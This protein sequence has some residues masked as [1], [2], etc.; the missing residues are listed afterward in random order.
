MT[1]FSS[2]TVATVLVAIDFA[3]AR[4]D[5]LVE[6]PGGSHQRFQVANTLSDFQEFASYLKALKQPCLIGFEATGNYHRALA[7]YLEQNGFTL[8][9]V[10][11]F[12]I[13][14]TREAL[15]NSWDKNDP[16]DCQAILQMLKTGMTQRYCDPLSQGIHEAQEIA[17]TY[18]QVSLR[19]VRVYHSIRTHFLP[20]YF[21]EAEK[22]WHRSRSEW[23]CAFLLRFPNPASVLRYTQEEFM[24]VAWEVAERKTNKTAW[25]AD[26]YQTAARSIGLPVAEDSEGIRMF[27]LILQEYLGLCRLRAEIEKHADQFLGEQ[28]DYRRLQTIPGIGPIGALTI[29]AEAGDLRRFSHYKKFLKYCGLDLCTR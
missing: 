5:V 4:N 16:K 3:K 11:S 12:A 7:H 28:A 24:R 1:Q 8:H 14:R 13:A 22:Y 19:R 20:L 18:Y 21:P 26:F 10:S 27:R 23:F 2:T 9:L 6:L 15:Y 17:R 29:L 25:L